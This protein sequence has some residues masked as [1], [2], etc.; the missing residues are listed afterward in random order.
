M[1]TPVKQVMDEPLACILI[2]GKGSLTS[3]RVKS[4]GPCLYS[5]V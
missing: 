5:A 4:Y 3:Q 2:L 1:Q